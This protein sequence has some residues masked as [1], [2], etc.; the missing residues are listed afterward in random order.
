MTSLDYIALGL[1]VFLAVLFVA[2]F[3]VLAGWPGRVATKRGH[4]YR[5]AVLIG[6]YATL[7]FGGV[8]WPLVLIWAY[9]GSPDEDAG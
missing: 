3:I 2:M 8:F 5:T 1:L 7:V 9:A 4:P 6:G